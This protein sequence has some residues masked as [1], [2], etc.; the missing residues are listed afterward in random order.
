[1]LINKKRQKEMRNLR[2]TKQPAKKTE[3][4]E[5]VPEQT[6]PRK[7]KTSP[8]YYKHYYQKKMISMLS[9][10]LETLKRNLVM[11]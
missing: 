4:T 5:E 9:L 10:L 2:M 11:K 3:I 7:K 6:P 1:M 8:L